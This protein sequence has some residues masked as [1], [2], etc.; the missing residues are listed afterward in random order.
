MSCCVNIYDFGCVG[1]CE[2]VEFPMIATQSGNHTFEF[3]LFGVTIT[4]TD[5]FSIGDAFDFSVSA[6][7]L[8]E[9]T[10][11]EFK[12][13]QPNGDYYIYE[14]EGVEYDCFKI[15]TIIKR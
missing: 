12:I 15:K 8:N 4:K 5:I 14:N 2:L 13:K 3:N 7:E 11:I 10:C 1:A 9:N 6:Y